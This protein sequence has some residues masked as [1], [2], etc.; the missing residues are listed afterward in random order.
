MT[1]H[2]SP[3]KYTHKTSPCVVPLEY[4]HDRDTESTRLYYSGD[5][6]T[7]AVSSG[8]P[9]LSSIKIIKGGRSVRMELM[10]HCHILAKAVYL[11]W[12]SPSKLIVLPLSKLITKCAFY[13]WNKRARK[14]P[15]SHFQSLGFPTEL[16]A[17]SFNMLPK[18]PSKPTHKR[19]G[20]VTALLY[21]FRRGI[22]YVFLQELDN[23]SSD[24]DAVA[25][26]D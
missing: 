16:L 26:S 24:E 18:N 12:R 13:L 20:T 9:V 5:N 7:S 19:V 22:A 6:R 1:N 2:F 25:A 15:A 3:S 4:I 10:N 14:R 21:S 8:T 11:N 17:T 23:G